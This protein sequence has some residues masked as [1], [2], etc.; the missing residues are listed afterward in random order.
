[1][2]LLDMGAEYY[3]YGSDITCSFP[4]SG[5]FTDNQKLIYNA[6]LDSQQTVEKHVKAGI[7]WNYLQKISE[8]VILKHLIQIGLVNSNNLEIDEL[9]SVHKISRIFM[10]HGFGH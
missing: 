3:N 10:P 2:L 4:I 1:M 6:V 8:I 7:S 9:V 5:K